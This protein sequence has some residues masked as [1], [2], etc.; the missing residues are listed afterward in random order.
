[1]HKTARAILGTIASKRVPGTASN[2]AIG[3]EAGYCPRTVLTYLNQLAAGGYI[4]IERRPPNLNGP[5][6]DP[7]GRTIRLTDLGKKA[8]GQREAA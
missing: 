8:A 2:A 5:G 7:T 4:T 1:M 6:T 3:R